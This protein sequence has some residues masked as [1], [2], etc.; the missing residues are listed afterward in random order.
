MSRS[1][2]FFLEKYSIFLAAA[3]GIDCPAGGGSKQFIWNTFQNWP[4][5]L[6]QIA[7][8]VNRK[9]VRSSWQR[10]CS[11]SGACRTTP[12]PIALLQGQRL[13]RCSCNTRRGLDWKGRLLH[14]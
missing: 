3:S 9:G 8:S 13:F 5:L 7:V 14:R 6:G 12:R 11:G 10:N 2:S 4:M 1:R